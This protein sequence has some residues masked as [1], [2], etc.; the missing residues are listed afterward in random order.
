MLRF[1]GQQSVLLQI[2]PTPIPHPLLRIITY[3]D[4]QESQIY[5]NRP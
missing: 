1:I 5:S 3:L 4:I 2:S